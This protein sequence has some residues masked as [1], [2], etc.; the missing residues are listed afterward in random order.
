M[1]KAVPPWL[2]PS[3]LWSLAAG[4]VAE[5]VHPALA[6]WMRD[7]SLPMP[8]AWPRSA[9]CLLSK[10]S[11][12]PKCPENLRPIALLHPISKCLA[13]LAAELLRPTVQALAERFPQFA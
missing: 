12:P 5:V 4:S 7:M 6:A 11:K 9:L 2:A 3:P 13:K 1:G 10:P 8:G